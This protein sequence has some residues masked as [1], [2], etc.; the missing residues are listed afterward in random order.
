MIRSRLATLLCTVLGLSALAPSV[1]SAYEG[2]GAGTWGGAGR[3]VVH[4]TTLDDSGPGSLREAVADGYRTVVFDVAGDIRLTDHIYVGGPFVTIDG[5]TA[6]A[7]GITLRN[8]GLII[9]GLRG[10]H[11]VI[12]RGLRIRNSSI[13]GL[14]VAYGAYNVVID[15]VSVSGSA[16][17][18]L[19]ITEDSQDVTIGWS[20]FAEPDYPYK[21]SLIKYRAQRVTLHH[22]LFIAA[23]QRNPLI[24]IDDVGTPATDTTVDMRNNVVWGWGSGHGTMVRNRAR[25]NLVGNYYGDPGGDVADAVIVDSATASQVYAEGNLSPD[26]PA[27]NLDGRGTE[28]VAF[29]A[30]PLTTQDACRAAQL[31]VAGAGVRPLDVVDAAFLGPVSIVGCGTTAPPPPPPPPPAPVAGSTLKIPVAPGTDDGRE[32]LTG[33]VRIGEAYLPFGRAN[34]VALRFANVPIPPGSM[35][36]GAVLRLSGVAGLGRSVAVRYVGE[37]SADSPPLMPVPFD[38]STRPKTTA[39]VDDVP[40]PWVAGPDN[41][42][43]DLGA[44]VREIVSRRDWRAGNSLTLFVLDAGSLSFRAM[45]SAETRPSPDAAAVLEITLRAP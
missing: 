33:I 45:G 34:T 11:D 3:E 25:V 8:R 41:P 38:F 27:L 7:P 18:N 43:P 36:Q 16:D 30:P 2:F 31:I 4:V 39:Y 17:G 42:S 6:P 44:V 28:A 32:Y 37:A 12:V 19:D 9:R 15:H 5:T 24:S 26:N 22:N 35:I 40:D 29:R 21:N 20:I 14:Q 23:T 10:A 1:V 13:D